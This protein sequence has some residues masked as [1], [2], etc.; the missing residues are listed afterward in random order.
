MT[1]CDS[2]ANAGMSL[3]ELLVSLVLVTILSV[4]LASAY[5]SGVR[6]AAQQT[7]REDSDV[8][9]YLAIKALRR[10]ISNAWPQARRGQDG[11][12][13]AEFEGEESQMTFLAELPSQFG[14]TGLSRLRVRVE[15]AA[16]HT[17]SLVLL[18]QRDFPTTEPLTVHKT[19]LIR[20]VVSMSLRY[21]GASTEGGAQWTT[22]WVNKPALPRLIGLALELEAGM[23]R[24]QEFIVATEL[25]Q[26]E[27]E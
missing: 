15:E 25:E 7:A 5:S 1:A 13:I 20:N 24:R 11:L 2:D 22:S 26:F 19:T 8:S 21:F 27:T 18:A 6:L 17:R 3:V 4:A 16:D 14:Q 12:L 10:L 23:P 9:R